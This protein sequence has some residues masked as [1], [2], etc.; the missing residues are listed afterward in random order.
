MPATAIGPRVNFE[1]LL[2]T[3]DTHKVRPVIDHVFPFAEYGDAYARLK[4][5]TISLRS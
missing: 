4:G 3:M 1:G 5:G 2:A